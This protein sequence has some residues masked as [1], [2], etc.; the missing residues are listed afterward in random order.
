MQNMVC[1]SDA[2]RGKRA[3]VNEKNLHSSKTLMSVQ[4]KCTYIFGGAT[5]QNYGAEQPVKEHLR[6]WHRNRHIDAHHAHVHL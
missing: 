5:G 6:Q 2:Y 1:V 3:P 4:A